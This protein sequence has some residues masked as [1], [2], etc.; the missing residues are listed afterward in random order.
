MTDNMLVTGGA[1][2][3]GANF[4]RYIQKVNPN[5]NIVNL[6]LLTY[7]GSLENLKNLALPENHQFIQGDICDQTLIEGLIRKNHID[8]IVHFAAESHVDRSL[9]GPKAFIQTNIMGTFSLLE[10]AR[11]VWLNDEISGGDSVRFHHIST[12]E[13]YGTLAPNDPAFQETTPYA[14][15]SPY[16]ASK[17]SSDHLVRSY[18]HSFGLPVTISNCSNNYGP[19]QFPEKLIPL[20]ILNALTGKPLPIYGDGMQ[21]RD[22]LYVVDHCEAI[23][24]II[25]NG[26][27][28]ESYN[29]GGGNQPPN[30]EIVKT[31][32]N[33][34]D[35]KG[36]PN[37]PYSS[38]IT[39][40]KDRP[41]HDRR[42]AMN[43]EKIRD[44]LGWQPKHELAE[45][46]R[47]TVE[48]YLDHNDWLNAIIKEKDYQKWV[49]LNYQQRGNK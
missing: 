29:I 42:Y 22:W 32:C 23:W 16:A 12:D 17:A 28:G 35:E 5:I 48:W 47:D 46:L 30:I 1:G 3:I 38:L 2:F 18:N 4:I 26:K 20:M 15:N 8:T 14:P 31:I 27:I 43:I 40:V 7:A 13:V 34:L 9:Q 36:L 24:S 6:D 25:Q 39:Y 49:Q 33:I 41:G 45:G 10:A 21:I 11:N 44:E 19:Y 37:S